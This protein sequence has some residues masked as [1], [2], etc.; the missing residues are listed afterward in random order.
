MGTTPNLIASSPFA[1]AA[2]KRTEG[3][4][5]ATQNFIFSEANDKF[6]KLIGISKNQLIGQ[7]FTKVLDIADSQTKALLQ[8]YITCFETQPKAVS[9]FYDER[10]GQMLRFQCWVTDAGEAGVMITEADQQQSQ[11]MDDSF[12]HEVF[13]NIAHSVFIVEVK[14]DGTFCFKDFNKTFLFYTQKSREQLQNKNIEDV[15]SKEIA[16]HLS[17]RYQKCLI[18]GKQITYEEEINFKKK[19]T[20]HFLTSL[21]PIKNNSEVITHLVGSSVEITERVEAKKILQLSEEKYRNFIQNSSEG[22][23]MFEFIKPMD[24]TLSLDEQINYIFKNG[25]FGACN[26]MMAKMYGYED[27]SGILG[28]KL[29]TFFG[30][31]EITMNTD[32]LKSIISSNY[33]VKDKLTVEFDRY[34]ETKYFMNNVSGVVENNKLVRVWA[35]QKDVTSEVLAKTKLQQNQKLLSATLRSIGDGVISCDR[36]GHI[37][38]IN[39]MAEKLTGW[40]S[41]EAKNKTIDEVFNIYNAETEEKAVSPVKKALEEGTTVGLANH[42]LLVSKSGEKFQIADSC[43]P[44]HDEQNNIIGCV[45]VFRDV[46]EEY[47]N[48]QAL[49][50]SEKRFRALTQNVPGVIYMCEIDEPYIPVFINKQILTLTGHSADDFMR[51]NILF[52]DLYHPDDAKWIPDK[53][54]QAVDKGEAFKLTYRMKH[55]NGD[56]RWVLEHGIGVYAENGDIKYLEG[57]IAD[58]TDQKEAENIAYKAAQQLAFHIENSPLAV[59]TFDKT[60]AIS[61]WSKSA[62]KLFGW[63]EKEVIQKDLLKP[64]FVHEE[65]LP[66]VKQT[67]NSLINGLEQRNYS[68]NRNLTKNGKELYCEWYNSAMFDQNGEIVSIFSLVHDVSGRYK[69]EKALKDSL[70]EKKTLL[71]EIHHRVKNNLAVV[72]AM[73]Q[74][75]AFQADNELLQEKLYDSVFRIKTMA[76]VHELLY[77]SN[78]FSNLDF[79]DTITKLIQNVSET[80]R[81]STEINM[82]IEVEHINLTI[83][84]AI[85]VSLIINEVITNIYKHA[86]VNKNSGSINYKCL[87][88]NGTV[89]LTIQDDGAGIDKVKAESG[90]SLGMHLIKELTQ[91][92]NGTFEYEKNNPGTVFRLSFPKK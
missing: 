75:Q 14:P 87:E 42:T 90:L 77:Q 40:S 51:G 47:K 22:I 12:L 37:L 52:S 67:M 28:K 1:F 44:I 39:K 24:I 2:H 58:I 6:E 34:G 48:K 85:P 36:H 46:T 91:Q 86:F 33:S 92:V 83:N 74:L 84:K 66:Q 31:E 54:K 50:N 59:V 60:G 70:R 62:E 80:L 11:A 79:S 81:A 30:A 43:A 16:D 23:Y 35:T 32:F 38:S 65:D 57:Y 3:Q 4:A 8:H 55:K 53:V 76:S 68:E 64:H 21:T 18:V 88:E 5:G 9:Y 20:K 13:K 10:S 61:Q 78:D 49:R 25:Y 19:G 63:K 41:D 89:K 29:G 45:L 72:S 15:F 27:N 7:P 26:E 82:N 17:L 71:A 73:M 56:W 69:Y